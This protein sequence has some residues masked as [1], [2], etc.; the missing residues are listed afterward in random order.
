[1]ICLQD[2]LGQ[3]LRFDTPPQRVVS[4][5]PSTTETLYKMGVWDSVVGVTR[6]CVHPSSARTEK[7]VIG[8][9]KQCNFEQIQ[10]LKPDVVLCNQEENSPEIVEKLQNMGIPVYVA[11]PKTHEDVWKDLHRLGVLF[12]KS[13]IIEEWQQQWIN[14]DL[15]KNTPAPEFHY[16]YL[17][18]RKPWMAVGVDTFIHQQLRLIGGVNRLSHEHNRYETIEDFAR[19]PKDTHLLLSSEP[20]PFTEKHRLELQELGFSRQNIHWIDGEFC[21]WHGARV[22]GSLTYLH[23]WVNQTF[24]ETR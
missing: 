23:N 8:G 13:P 19:I 14:H 4:L 21:S 9:T 24:S 22:V 5:V 16:L 7:S 1:M 18:W 17:I 12:D 2:D 20:F 11:F 6:Y 15:F 10:A 3:T